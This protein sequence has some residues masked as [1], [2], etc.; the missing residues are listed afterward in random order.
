MAIAEQFAGLQMD[1]LIGAPLRAAADAST[2]LANSTADFIN[3]VGFD[4]AGKVRTVAFGYQ[5]RSTNEDGTSN[6]DEMKV[7]EGREERRAKREN[8]GS[9][10]TGG[11]GETGG[12][13]S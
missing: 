7:D 9:E 12:V 10:E 2:Q 4:N 13:L 5:K 8:G 1:Q 11:K 3:R 6:L